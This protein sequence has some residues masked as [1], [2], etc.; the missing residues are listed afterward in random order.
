[1]QVIDERDIL[2]TGCKLSDP[3][4]HS[5]DCESTYSCAHE[6]KRENGP[7][8]AEKV[9]LLHGVP[10]MK[11]D[12]RKKNVEEDLGIKGGF[13][14]NFTLI[15]LPYFSFQVINPSFI[16]KLHVGDVVFGSF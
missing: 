14:I 4:H 8:V 9:F 1:M 10:G 2:K 11:N 5:P 15:R 13:Q 7:D 3:I 12:R 16:F 6:R